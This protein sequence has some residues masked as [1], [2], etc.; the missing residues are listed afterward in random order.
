MDSTPNILLIR[1]KSIGDI[2]FLL[3]SVHRLRE[4][5]PGARITFLT[6]RENAPLME[7]FREVNEVIT[8]D[9]ARFQSGNPGAILAEAFSLLRR[10]RRGKFSLVVD[11]QGTARRRGWPG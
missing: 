10:L 4:N 8:L 5:F 2:L 7:G 6:S 3:P 1:L 9:R 11:F